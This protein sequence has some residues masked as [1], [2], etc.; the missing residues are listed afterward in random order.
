MS[1]K[2]MSAAET[3]AALRRACHDCN[4]TPCC[5]YET[6]GGAAADLIEA[7]EAELARVTA[8]RDALKRYVDGEVLAMVTEIDG[9][10]LAHLRELVEAERDGRCV[11]LPC[12][13]GDTAFVLESEDEDG[14]DDCIFEGN[15]VAIRIGATV[16]IGHMEH[17]C[18]FSETERRISDL[19][20]D[21]FLTRAEAEA[22]Q[23]G[24][25]K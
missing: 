5:E 2:T 12:K 11:V 25:E 9:V 7:K 14:G 1:D 19:S 13:I 15:I 17:K 23:G 16:S 10:P 4:P 21:W 18:W 22:A 20:V 8:E 24:G 6:L 3:V